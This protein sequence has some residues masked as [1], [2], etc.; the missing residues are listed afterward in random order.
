MP[1]KPKKP[2]TE[3]MLLS[4]APHQIAILID[5]VVQDLTRVPERM[6]ALFLSE[7]K[8]VYVNNA[9]FPKDSEGRTVIGLTRLDEETNEW[10]HLEEDGSERREPVGPSPWDVQDDE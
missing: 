2:T 5:G 3:Q 7:P 10:V 6:A 9:I 1:A 8:F 4:Q